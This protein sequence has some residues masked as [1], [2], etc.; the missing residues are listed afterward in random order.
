M[1]P[2]FVQRHA[3]LC[4]L[5]SDA[6]R[7]LTR[8]FV[9]GP[10]EPG[11]AAATI[12]DRKAVKRMSRATSLATAAARRVLAGGPAVAPDLALFVAAGTGI[13]SAAPMLEALVD[14]DGD[15]IVSAMFAGH[16]GNVLDYLTYSVNMVGGTIA[17]HT[18]IHARNATY[19]GASAGFLALR[20]A[21]RLLGAGRARQAVVV[22]GESLQ[23]RGL[24]ARAPAPL[25]R[26]IGCALWL[27]TTRPAG[28]AWTIRLGAQP[29]SRPA[30]FTHFEAANALLNLCWAV[31]LAGSDRAPHCLHETDVWQRTVSYALAPAELS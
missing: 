3:Y 2:V 24:S 16:G 19:V 25:P 8:D 12:G 26:E 23:E 27:S 9:D 14:S 13:S 5:G 1:V 10:A 21:L 28:D 30:R 11:L 18:G 7:C 20:A 4:E 15:D 31:E 6:E 17:E 22:S 29:A